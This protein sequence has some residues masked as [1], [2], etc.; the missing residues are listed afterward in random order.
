MAEMTNR[1]VNNER[2]PIFSTTKNY[3][4]MIVRRFLEREEE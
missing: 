2:K 1:I 3:G 4:L